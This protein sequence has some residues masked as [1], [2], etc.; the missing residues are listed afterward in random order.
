PRAAA[1]TR[2][3]SVAGAC[4]ARVLRGRGARRHRPLAAGLPAGPAT[5]AARDPAQGAV[6][7]M[8]LAGAGWQHGT[9]HRPGAR[10]ALG[11]RVRAGPRALPP[12]PGQPLARVL[13]RG[14]TAVPG[15]ARRA[16]ILPP[17]RPAPEGTPAR[18]AGLRHRSIRRRSRAAPRPARMPGM[19]IP[20]RP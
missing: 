7:A 17:R 18:A 6:L 9:G 1:A 15:L 14:G 16:R 19:S 11:L 10:T 8:G 4:A 2:V 3:A 13:A 20:E 12:A 5:R